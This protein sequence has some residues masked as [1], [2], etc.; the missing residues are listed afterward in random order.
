MGREARWGPEGCTRCIT[1]LRRSIGLSL[2]SGAEQGT[3]WPVAWAFTGRAR[4]PSFVMLRLEVSAALTDKNLDVG[5]MSYF[6]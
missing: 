5:N 4:T 1:W 6:F 2:T 3:C